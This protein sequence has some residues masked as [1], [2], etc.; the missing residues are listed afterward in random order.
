M[1]SAFVLIKVEDGDVEE[2]RKSLEE[3]PEVKEHYSVLGMYEVLSL[4]KSETI[5]DLQEYV[6]ST[7]D[8]IGGV[9]TTL[10]LIVIDPEPEDIEGDITE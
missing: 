10:T 5:T 2:I 9:S 1:A 8:K 6:S 3:M 7:I 4:V